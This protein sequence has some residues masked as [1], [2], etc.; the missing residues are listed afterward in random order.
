MICAVCGQS[1]KLWRVVDGYAYTDCTAC[2]SIAIDASSM[3]QVDEGRFP[4]NYDPTYWAKEDRAARARSWG[5]SLARVAETVLYCRRPIRRFL[6]IGSGPGHLLDALSAYLPTRA[7]SHFL[8]VEKFPPD[9]HTSHP[10]YLVG[11]VCDL[12]A[13]VDAGICVEV[14]E[15]LTPTQFDN[16]VRQLASRSSPGS[17][18]LFNTGLPDYV[19]NEDP[20]YID[21]LGRGH[22]VSWGWPALTDIFGRHGFTVFPVAGK[23]F[24]FVAEHQSSDP[25][26][27]RDRIWSPPA[28][29][30]ELLR[31]P[32]MGEV[33]Y[34][35]GLESA[36]A[37]G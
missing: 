20:N 19:K 10:G 2:G 22:I 5:S 35:L 1:A 27:M 37:Y 25:T 17:L 13:P 21:P 11:E 16:I 28:E 7:E 4:R 33:L 9:T 34:M 36:R 24:A 6:D 32:Q 15:H 12:D 29:N 26:P 3:R 31:D 14:V 23:S 30:R 18:F 8:A